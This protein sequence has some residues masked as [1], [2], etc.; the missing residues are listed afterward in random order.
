MFPI[1]LTR[2]TEC[3]NSNYTSEVSGF[4]FSRTQHED[5]Y[6][7]LCDVSYFDVEYI[8]GFVMLGGL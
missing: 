8:Y 7:L 2:L 5:F 1:L 4:R 6:P 3:N